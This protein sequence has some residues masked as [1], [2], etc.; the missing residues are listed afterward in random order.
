M[1]HDLAPTWGDNPDRPQLAL[2]GEVLPH[3]ID[4]AAPFDRHPNLVVQVPVAAVC[5]VV[6][7]EG[8]FARCQ[9]L[10]AAGRVP[11]PIAVSAVRVG[12]EVFY[13]VTDGN[14]RTEAAR[15]AGQPTIR[16]ALDCTTT[17]GHHVFSRDSYGEG[18]WRPR[19]D[20]TLLHV[21]WQSN[22]SP[23]E[24]RALKWLVGKQKEYGQ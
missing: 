5:S 1:T 17:V 10:L 16:A 4:V 11:P 14:H 19:K 21:A 8:R 9:E 18:L 12:N 24:W 3:L 15:A 6:W 7:S 2:I 20:G 23:P 13:L 22:F